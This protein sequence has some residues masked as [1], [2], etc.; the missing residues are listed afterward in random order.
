MHYHV[1]LKWGF[2][3]FKGPKAQSAKNAGAFTR[4]ADCLQLHIRRV[5]RHECD[6][7]GRKTS[8]EC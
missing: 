3:T 8:P 2:V 5:R 4:F 1:E 6:Y 7:V